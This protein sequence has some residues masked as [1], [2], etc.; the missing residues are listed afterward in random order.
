[1]PVPDRSEVLI[2]VTAPPNV[3]VTVRVNEEE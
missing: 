3:K 1:V 2:E